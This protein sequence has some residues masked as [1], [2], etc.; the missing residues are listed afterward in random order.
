MSI[1]IES[2]PW[3]LFTR[4]S[5]ELANALSSCV[6]QLMLRIHVDTLYRN[7]P[8][9]IS[10]SN[11]TLLSIK[12]SFVKVISLLLNHFEVESKVFALAL[13][14]KVLIVYKQGSSCDPP[15]SLLK[16]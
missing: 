7:P 13:L 9:P 16:L 2:I 4:L 6:I 15:Y 3:L 5:C 1:P 8:A 11:T 10:I 12:Q 14:R